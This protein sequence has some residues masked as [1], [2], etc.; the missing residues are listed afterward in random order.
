MIFKVIGI[1]GVYII[2]EEFVVRNLCENLI[3][4]C[5]DLLVLVL[6]INM[7]E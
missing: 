6:F 7:L 5:V 2:K 4:V 3:I 1:V